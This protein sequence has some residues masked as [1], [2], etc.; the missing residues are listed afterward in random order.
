MSELFAPAL[1]QLIVECVLRLRGVL[2]H[3]PLQVRVVLGL[4]TGGLVSVLICVPSLGG[5]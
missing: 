4:I 2:L 5:G 1:C 3:Q